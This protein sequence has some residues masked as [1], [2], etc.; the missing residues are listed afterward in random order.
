MAAKCSG[1]RIKVLSMAGEI[2]YSLE[3]D[4]SWKVIEL[5][6]QIA[7]YLRPVKGLF[8]L[9][10]EDGVLQDHETLA[11]RL[12]T[13]LTLDLE[14][15]LIFEA[16]DLEAL[17]LPRR[18]IVDRRARVVTEDVEEL[19]RL[20]SMA[21]EILCQEPSV[22]DLE[23]PLTLVAHLAGRMDQLNT[24]FTQLGEPSSQT[25]Y[26]FLGNYLNRGRQSSEVL[27]MLLAYKCKF[28]EHVHLLRGQQETRKATRAKGFYD[29]CKRIYNVKIW[30]SFMEVLDHLP[31]CALVKSRI[32]CVS[33]GLSPRTCSLEQLRRIPRPTAAEG[34]E[35]VCDLLWSFPEELP[36]PCL[37]A[38]EGCCYGPEVVKQFLKDHQLELVVQGNLV[39]ESGYDDTFA[40]GKLVTVFSC[41]NYAE[42]RV[43]N[44]GAV[45]RIHEDLTY[46]FCTHECIE[47]HQ[48]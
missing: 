28:P 6:Q 23:P 12:G 30:K 47:E 7:S 9:S 10:L 13:D 14:V 34:D 39:K 19:R 24:I 2:L 25:P 26:L 43:S 31:L 48:V 8:Q 22:L 38:S 45:M 21:K 1:V 5:K 33:G 15:T 3:A 40:D 27:I 41:A 46:I 44:K 29:E 32:F 42:E 20:C 37:A 17:L 18:C 11:D 35:L 36:L 16:C 4:Q